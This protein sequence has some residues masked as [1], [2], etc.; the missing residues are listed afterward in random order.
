MMRA[1]ETEGTPKVERALTDLFGIGDP[2][3]AFVAKLEQQLR[4]QCVAA[5]PVREDPKA[6][7]RKWLAF[8]PR[9]RWAFAVL[10]IVLAL[11]VAV[12]AVG[13]ARV[14]ADIQNLLWRYVP[15]FGFID[16][17]ESRLMAEPTT[18]K[19]DGVTLRLAQVVA[20]HDGTVVSLTVEGLPEP[21]P[22]DTA[23]EALQASL[24]LPD[25]RS[26]PLTGSLASWGQAQIRFPAMPSG[27]ISGTLLLERLP[28]ARP[29]SLPEGWRVPFSLRSAASAVA[30]DVFPRA[31]E[32]AG[33][34]QTHNGVTLRV[35]RVAHSAEATALEVEVRWAN[36]SW[37][38]R[39]L[40]DRQPA[41][42]ADDLGHVY[43]G[44]AL[45]NVAAASFSQEVATT[46]VV[47]VQPGT[48]PQMPLPG[49]EARTLVYTPVSS[50]ARRLTLAVNGVTFAGN[51]SYDPTTPVT[52]DLGAAPQ[53]GQHWS[54]ERWLD[55][56]GFPVHLVGASLEKTTVELID[57][58]KFPAFRLRSEVE[59]L[60]SK[61]G[62]RLA[63]VCFAV[64]QDATRWAYGYECGDDR[65]TPGVTF[66]QLPAGN[67]ALQASAGEIAVSGPWDLAWDVP[68]SP[69]GQGPTRA[70]RIVRPANAV[71]RA[72][73]L[74]LR[75]RE[76]VMTDRV[77]ALALQLE[78]QGGL[79]LYRLP[80]QGQQ[81]AFIHDDHGRSYPSA[82]GIGWQPDGGLSDHADI[83]Y[84]EPVAA[85]ATYL[86][87]TL[88]VVEIL[89]SGRASFDVRVPPGIKLDAEQSAARLSQGPPQN[90]SFAVDIPVE[91]GG[92]SFRFAHAYVGAGIDGGALMLEAS[93]DIGRGRK[94]AGYCVASVTTPSGRPARAGRHA[95]PV[96]PCDSMLTFA[97]GDPDTGVVEPG[98]YHV[99]LDGL[100]IAVPGPWHFAWDV[101][102]R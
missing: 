17:G 88:P 65:Q 72:S 54:F 96:E 63:S 86:Q 68:E 93:P 46:T 55:V 27:A 42:L 74:T 70:P 33:A 9:Q 22:A 83:L 23:N 15:D 87:F 14:L 38:L 20:Q 66:A 89:V 71:A 41:S 34:E 40:S 48:S 91:I 13:P 12:T 1:S 85:L 79:R 2:D 81:S 5:A 97:V 82:E 8:L 99:E 16:A 18:A 26:L 10:A 29:G 53:V 75:L 52:L 102:A 98:T 76:A 7:S 37:Y 25:G 77:T 50:A 28:L 11:V 61:D 6:G 64:G 30:A 84:L 100:V 62:A 47:Q 3:P 95:L 78:D 69:I 57:R 90:S 31:Y 19:R 56:S 101:P 49:T 21:G 67:V 59:P 36:Q 43:G 73:G 32:P 45:R 4:S 24:E 39:N 80:E 92:N 60:P 94:L 35:R 44:P 51:S 58:G